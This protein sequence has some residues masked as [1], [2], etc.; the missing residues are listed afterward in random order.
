M[1]GEHKGVEWQRG[2]KSAVL[3][4]YARLHARK[5]FLHWLWSAVERVAAGEPEAEV[6]RDYGY[7][8]AVPLHVEKYAPAWV[9]CST[10]DYRAL[11]DEGCSRS[12]CPVRPTAVSLSDGVSGG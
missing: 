11:R 10:C 3:D 4:T 7:V 12:D 9:Q 2:G 8:R 1:S 6:M 5:L